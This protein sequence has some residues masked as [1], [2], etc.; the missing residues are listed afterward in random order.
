V[1]VRIDTDAL[2]ENLPIDV[3]NQ[4]LDAS[5]ASQ[6]TKTGSNNRSAPEAGDRQK[7]D[8]LAVLRVGTD[9]RVLSV[10]ALSCADAPEVTDVRADARILCGSEDTRAEP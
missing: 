7:P 5:A 4:A 6:P 8:P 1:A 10:R 2:L 3:R 9:V